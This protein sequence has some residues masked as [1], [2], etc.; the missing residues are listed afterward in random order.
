MT[1]QAS[2]THLEQLWNS[3]SD[4]KKVKTGAFK[5]WKLD[6]N[7]PERFAP[8]EFMGCTI[9]AIVDGTGVSIGHIP[10]ENNR[11]T[12]LEDKAKVQKEVI[13]KMGNA[14]TPEYDL[15]DQSVAYILFKPPNRNQNRSLTVW[16]TRE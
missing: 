11:C 6:T 10:E 12:I 3:I 7:R 8:S 4:S 15:S 16:S 2:T 5:A 13:E 14:I 1:P 9:V